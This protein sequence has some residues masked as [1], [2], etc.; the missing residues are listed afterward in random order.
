MKFMNKV[1]D[2]IQERFGP[3]INEVLK[4]IIQLY[5]WV[6][7]NAK[8][9]GF[10]AGTLMTALVVY[11]SV[12]MFTKLWT[13]AQWLLNAA[14][15]ANPIGLIIAGIAA[16]IAAVVYAWY[17]F[18]GFR[19]AVFGLWEAFKQVFGGI[20]ELVGSVMGGVGELILGAL[21][22]D[23]GKIKSGLAKLG[24]G[25]ANYGRGVVDAY[26]AGSEAGKAFEPKVPDFL[27]KMGGQQD[28]LAMGGFAGIDGLSDQ[29][30]GDVNVQQG[31]S[32]ITGGGSRPTNITIN[33]DKFQD[34]IVI[35]ANNMKDGLDR[36]EEQVTEIFLRV[37][38]SANKVATQ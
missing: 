15:T 13:A 18:D 26:K 23:M 14:M 7:R 3:Y 38:N 19:G 2:Q 33:L 37:I 4:K 16:L 21:T 35:N 29:I 24:Q 8:M 32:G 5:H 11:K 36:L 1:G 17:K 28:G 25:F 6:G 30:G 12:I 10:F 31:V 34:Q 22:F 9:I 20:R 27:K